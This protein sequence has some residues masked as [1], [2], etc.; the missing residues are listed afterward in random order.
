MS[1]HLIYPPCALTKLA[2]KK[3]CFRNRSNHDF[4]MVKQK[5]SLDS[6]VTV[7]AAR[8]WKQP[9]LSATK[10]S[11]PLGNIWFRDLFL[12][13]HEN[14]GD[15]PFFSEKFLQSHGTYKDDSS[16]ASTS[17][18]LP[19]SD[20][21]EYSFWSRTSR[22]KSKWIVF[23]GFEGDDAHILY[24]ISLFLCLYGWFLNS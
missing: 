7:E 8:D 23:G 16:R 10:K 13:S 14:K 5:S 20:S 6:A 11:H 4:Q 17:W 18:L 22:P 3:P 24:Q 19:I 21:T 15:G 9:T 2:R 1:F 12:N